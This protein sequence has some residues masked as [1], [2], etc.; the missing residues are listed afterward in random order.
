M[1]KPVVITG[2]ILESIPGLTALGLIMNMTGFKVGKVRAF[3]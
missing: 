2:E 1:S 3:T